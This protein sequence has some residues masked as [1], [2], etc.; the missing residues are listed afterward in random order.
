MRCMASSLPPWRGALLLENLRKVR[1]DAYLLML[2]ESAP[3]IVPWT[4]VGKA[5]GKHGIDVENL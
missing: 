2:R 5:L 3:P 4:D 1:W